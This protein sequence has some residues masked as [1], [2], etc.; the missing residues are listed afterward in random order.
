MTP[1]NTTFLA[2]VTLACG[3]VASAAEPS[4]RQPNIV[5]MLSDDQAWNGLSVAMAPDAALPASQGFQTPHL[6]RLAAEGMRFSDAYAPAPVCSP[7]RISL[8]AGL[9]PARLHWTKAAPRE[10]GQRLLEPVNIRDIP[11][12][13]TTIGEILQQAGYVTAHFGKWHISG[14]GPG[15]H[16]YD[17]HDGD[18]GNEHAY[19]FTDPN[20]VDIFGMAER[21]ASFMQRATAAG[22]PFYVQLSWNALHAPQ[23]ARKATLAKYGGDNDTL[24]KRIATLA[25]TED[26]D[27]GVGRVLAAIDQL[28]IADNTYVI[29]MSDNGGGSGKRGGLSG[30]KGSVWEGGIRVPLIV[31]GPGVAAG[32]W[33]DVPVVGYDL[34]PTFCR[35]AGIPNAKLPA[36]LDGGSIDGLLVAEGRGVVQRWRDEL[37][38]HFPHYQSEGG[39]Q[40]A[41]RAGDF[42][43]IRLYESGVDQLFNLR[44]DRGEQNDLITQQPAVATELQRRLES[45]LLAVSA[46]MPTP[47]P[48]FDPGQPPPQRRRG[49]SEGGQ[50]NG[51]MQ[52]KPP[53][54]QKGPGQ[55]GGNQNGQPGNS[56]NGR[57]KPGAAP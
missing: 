37:V 33:C 15:G 42:K 3:I 19:Q 39:P 9:N 44:E 52:G 30:G 38:F 54:D 57:E 29:Y 24:D 45:H 55:K 10:Q 46:Q 50:R 23:N 12:E 26:L 36:Q 4:G 8:Q 17:E 35:W 13:L 25:I 40:S 20:P 22:R 41:I 2:F 16:G 28:G 53:R 6:E 56:Q 31:R 1:I 7:T 51:G 21:T 5:F 48:A 18:T 43:L 32:S 49:K 47:N 14:G 34:Y 27:E 11:A